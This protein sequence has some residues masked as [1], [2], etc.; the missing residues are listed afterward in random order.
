[1]QRKNRMITMRISETDHSLIKTKA[2][3][4]KLNMT[5]YITRSA[6]DKPVVVI[7]GL[8]KITSELMHIGHNLN[9]LTTLC[10]MGKIKCLD[11]DETRRGFGKIHDALY[12]L[13]ERH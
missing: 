5:E 4:A 11:L 9:Q 8:D 1:M 10:N 3:R 12:S 6:L 2:S 13:M 7:D